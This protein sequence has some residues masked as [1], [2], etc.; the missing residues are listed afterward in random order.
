MPDI[1]PKMDL[2][3]KTRNNGGM[4]LIQ[5]HH[6]STLEP[7]FLY[8]CIHDSY[9]LSYWDHQKVDSTSTAFFGYPIGTTQH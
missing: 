4:I 9:S 2:S 8:P 7:T 3:Q 5:M 6:G 1:D